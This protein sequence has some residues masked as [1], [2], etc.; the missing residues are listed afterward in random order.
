MA[1][2]KP[3][4]QQRD[5]AEAFGSVASDYDRFRPSYPDALVDDLVALHPG[6]VLDVGCGTA[7]AARQLTARGLPVLGVEIDSQMAS[8]ARGHGIEVEV[9]DFEK[10]DDRG[11]TFDLI[12]SAQA[13]HWVD[14]AL[15]VPKA[16][17]LLN[18]GGTLAL[19]WNFEDFVDEEQ[20]IVDTVYAEHAPELAAMI[21]QGASHRDDR[22]YADDLRVGGEFGTVTTHTYEWTKSI[23]VDFWIRREGTQSAH[24]LLEPQRLRG[25]QD[26]LRAA[27]TAHGDEVHTRGGTYAIRARV[28]A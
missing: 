23:P 9:S 19:F 18:P 2:G 6:A 14:P 12:I 17:R 21:A 13:W 8:V 26:A 25:L 20:R 22:S 1:T 3:I 4:H 15:A 5:R 24:L 16:A 27:L 28:E 7:I 10:W 11:R